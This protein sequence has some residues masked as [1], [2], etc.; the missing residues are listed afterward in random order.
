MTGDRGS[1]AE[2]ASIGGDPAAASGRRPSRRPDP[3]FWRGRRVFLTGHTG[4]K[5][6]WLALALARLGAVVTGY[7]LAPETKPALFE[8]AHVGE[9]VASEIGD[10]RD[11]ARLEA[12]IAAAA[13]EIVLHLAAQPIVRRA[14]LEPVE[15]FATNVMGTVHLLDALRRID[16]VRA[17]IV[18]T[19]DKVYDNVEWAWPYRETDRLGAKEAY[20][21]SKAAAEIAVEAWR[22]AFLAERGVAVATVR[23]GNII[24]GGDWAEDR[25]VPDAMRA[26]ARGE[27]VVI[28]NPAAIRPWQHVLEPVGAYLMLAEDLANGAAPPLALNFGPPAADAR[29][30]ADIVGRLA[31]LWGIDPGWVQDAGHHPY[32]ARHLTLDSSL[33]AAKLR[34]SPTWTLDQALERTVGWYK[35]FYEGRD[36]RARTLAEIEEHVGV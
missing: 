9:A 27:P 23:A 5:G 29:T 26:F 14:R 8:A 6:G 24:G 7:A 19:S 32:E 22:H 21:G 2:S 31:R 25:L 12:A 13:P 1:R 28:R 30:V 20:G 3:G 17:V 15:T 4:F 16:S 11:R 33:A 36:A 18:V 34:W 10:I 35:H